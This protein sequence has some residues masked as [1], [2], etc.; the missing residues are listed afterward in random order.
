MVNNTV[1]QVAQS[2]ARPSVAAVKYVGGR[3]GHPV[4]PTRLDGTAERG[5]AEGKGNVGRVCERWNTNTFRTFATR[6]AQ[7][8]GNGSNG[9]V[10]PTNPIIRSG[11]RRMTI[12]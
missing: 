9:I 1:S 7:A 8:C 4:V 2:N 12:R 10:R 11:E 6:P 5:A 3:S